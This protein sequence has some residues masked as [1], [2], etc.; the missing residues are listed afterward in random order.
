MVGLRILFIDVSI[1]FDVCTI[2]WMFVVTFTK[3]SERLIVEMFYDM[4]CLVLQLSHLPELRRYNVSID[5]MM[6]KR[7]HEPGIGIIFII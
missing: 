2:A 1:A 4:I 7:F 5:S 6:A 3:V